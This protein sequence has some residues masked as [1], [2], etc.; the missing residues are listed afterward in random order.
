[1]INLIKQIQNQSLLCVYEKH[2]ALIFTESTAITTPS[3][4]SY[5]VQSTPRVLNE[6]L[7]NNV[8][9][10]PQKWILNGSDNVNKNG[11]GVKM[12][13]VKQLSRFQ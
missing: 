7:K 6:K 1:M 12:Q 13:N 9:I 2:F 8:G 4:W 10:T 11:S 3:Q 5:S